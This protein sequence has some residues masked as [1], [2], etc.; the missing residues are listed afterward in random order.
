MNI[1]WYND[2]VL[3]AS[4]NNVNN[5]THNELFLVATSTTSLYVLN[6]SVNDGEGNWANE[7]VYFT[8]EGTG[9]G[10]GVTMIGDSNRGV[11]FVF[12]IIGFIG[13]LGLLGIRRR[14]RNNG[15]NV[16]YGRRY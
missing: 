12:S 6:I 4:D 15:G 5:G 8:T 13:I 1:S 10:G 3:I 11:I 9:V 7:T 14:K 2:T 16:R